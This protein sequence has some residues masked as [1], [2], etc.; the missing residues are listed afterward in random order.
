MTDADELRGLL[1]RYARAVDQRDVDTLTELFHPDALIVGT[2]GEQTLDSWLDTMRGPRAFP[3]SMHLIGD[4][5]VDLAEDGE[6][7]HSTPTPSRTSSEIAAPGRRISRS[8]SG[9]PTTSSGRRPMGV[10][11]AARRTL[12]MR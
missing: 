1:Q 12:W 6:Q 4:P 5:L 10:P 2:R 3:V 7:A 9:I 11:A 8:A